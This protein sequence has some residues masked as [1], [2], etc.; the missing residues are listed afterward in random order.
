MQLYAGFFLCH[1]I[2]YSIK[3]QSS[4]QKTS[5][6]LKN[7]HFFKVSAFRSSLQS[8]SFRVVLFQLKNLFNYGTQPAI[9]SLD[10]EPAAVIY[11]IYN[12]YIQWF[13]NIE[14][15]SRDFSENLIF[16][17]Q[18]FK[19]LLEFSNPKKVMN[20]VQVYCRGEQGSMGTR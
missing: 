16:N 18:L 13:V 8:H 14:F 15:N 9:S 12:I 19:Y 17:I 3:I 2:K 4:G 10:I 7:R 6:N 1:T 20:F 5:L 11:I